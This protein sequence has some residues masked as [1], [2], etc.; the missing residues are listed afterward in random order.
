MQVEVFSED[1]RPVHGEKGD[2]V[3]TRPF[4]SM[5]VGFWNDPDGRRYR[6]AYFERY[7]DVWHHGDFAS[8]D[9]DALS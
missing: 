7:D 2:L 1:G 6:A 3:C 4:P 9:A 5:P 8:R